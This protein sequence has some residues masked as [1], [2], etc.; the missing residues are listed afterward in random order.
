MNKNPTI[1][2]S[3]FGKSISGDTIFISIC[4]PVDLPAINAAPRMAAA[5][6]RKSAD[7]DDKSIIS[8]FYN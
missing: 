2:D 4:L 1:F 3:A 8:Y 5:L 7:L 6:N